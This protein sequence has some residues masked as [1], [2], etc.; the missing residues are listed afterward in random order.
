MTRW[1]TDQLGTAPYEQVDSLSDC[2]ILDVRDLVD[3]GGNT[4]GAVADLLHQGAAAMKSGRKVVVCC[5][6]G[7]SRSNAIAAG[8]LAMTGSDTFSAAVER[9]LT[10][11]GETQIKPQ[12][13]EIVGRAGG[14]LPIRRRTSP[15][16]VIV[17]GP[18]LHPDDALMPALTAA[19]LDTTMIE[20]AALSNAA[21]LHL[22]TI[23]C[24]AGTVLHLASPAV[25]HVNEAVG[26]TL[27]MLKN[28][29]DVCVLNDLYLVYL[30]SAEVF[31]GLDHERVDERAPVRPRSTI[32]Q[33]HALAEQLIDMHRAV[34]QLRAAVLRPGVVYGDP[35]PGSPPMFLRTFV[36]R[37]AE[38]E[39]IVTHEY[40]NGEPALEL[41]HID[42]LR[43]AMIHTLLRQPDGVIH[44]GTAEAMTTRQI[45][46]FIIGATG[47][48]SERRT[49]NLDDRASN[50]RLGFDRAEHELGWTAQIDPREG[51][52]RYI[53]LWNERNGRPHVG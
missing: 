11:T 51:L 12:M 2:H 22:R 13:I 43:A 6:R 42:D 14:L 19:S 25:P 28:V 32:G 26:Q 29:L 37:A 18:A 16:N 8:V 52:R 35:A 4:A 5:D 33:T 36:Q 9:V 30:S 24:D 10:A 49:L 44:L 31:S 41:L 48:A 39:A 53:A 34:H 45:A 50:I 20:G 7:M 27:S 40:L 23:E 17:T 21:L 3:R 1:I 38:N 46:E 15:T 47:S